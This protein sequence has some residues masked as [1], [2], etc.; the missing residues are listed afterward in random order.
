MHLPVAGESTVSDHEPDATAPGAAA[1]GM[2]GEDRRVT[3]ARTTDEWGIDASWV[4]ALDEEHEVAEATIERLREVIG[5]PPA[6][7]EDRAPIVARP[8]DALEVD[9]AEVVCED[10]QTRSIDG[11]LPDDLDRKSVV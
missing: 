4:D 2:P 3:H 5:Q 9:E 6:D 11:E 7:L 10:G 8:G 1:R